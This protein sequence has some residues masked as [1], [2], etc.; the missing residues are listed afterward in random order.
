MIF[1][2]TRFTYFFRQFLL[3]KIAITAT[4]SAFRMYEGEGEGGVTM[5]PKNDDA[6]YE[7][8]LHDR[9]TDTSS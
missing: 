4:F 5:T 1:D 3:A 6:I 8:P 9:L 7:Q 2:L